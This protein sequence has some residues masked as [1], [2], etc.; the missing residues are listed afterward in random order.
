VPHVNASLEERLQALED[1]EEIL[2]TMYQYAHALDYG[3]DA[4]ELTDCFTDD[5]IWYSTIE[6]VW[7]GG[8]D[9]RYEG[10]Q[11]LAEWF[12]DVTT[13][14][15]PGH[16][17]KHVMVEPDI[18]LEGDQA[19]VTSYFNSQRET[20]DGPLLCSMGRYMDILVRCPDGRWRIKQRHCSMENVHRSRQDQPV[21]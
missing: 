5:G 4:S 3:S 14:G 2:R 17:Q 19:I 1:R 15:K 9:R 16:F 6:G 8:S 10:K 18:R 12:S 13:R 20:A 11:Q 21:G 7:A